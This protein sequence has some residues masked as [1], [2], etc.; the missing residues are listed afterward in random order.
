MATNEPSTHYMISIIIRQNITNIN[1]TIPYQSHDKNS[2][3]QGQLRF[4]YNWHSTN[5]KSL[6]LLREH[7]RIL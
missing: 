6:T 3:Q 2:T 7:V 1:T 5:L 4:K